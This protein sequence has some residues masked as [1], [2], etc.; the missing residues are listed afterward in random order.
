MQS[1][2]KLKKNRNAEIKS[3]YF[4]THRM[5]KNRVQPNPNSAQWHK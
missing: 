3:T 2:S 4:N 1:F 5:C